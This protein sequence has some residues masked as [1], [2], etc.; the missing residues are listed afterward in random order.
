MKYRRGSLPTK[1]YLAVKENN[2]TEVKRLIK[3]K[4]L[5]VDQ[6]FTSRRNSALHI[7]VEKGFWDMFETLLQAACNVN[8]RSRDGTTPF[9]LA[10]ALVESNKFSERL[11]DE[12]A[13]INATDSSMFNFLIY[14]SYHLIYAC[15]YRWF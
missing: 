8:V 6:R 10:C 11:L 15:I 9:L 12:G 5:D 3:T 2:N 13:N 7:A 14:T 4:G 1:F